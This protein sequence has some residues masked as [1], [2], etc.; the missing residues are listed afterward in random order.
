LSLKLSLYNDDRDER[1]H[2]RVFS[3]LYPRGKR[4]NIFR[5]RLDNPKIYHEND[6]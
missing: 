3:L 5:V 1:Y 4:V 6:L 2:S